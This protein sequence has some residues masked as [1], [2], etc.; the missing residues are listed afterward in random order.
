[1]NTA[2]WV[3]DMAY[4]LTQVLKLPIKSTAILYENQNIP[5]QS[6]VKFMQKAWEIWGVEVKSTDKFNL[7]DADCTQLVIKMRDLA[8]DFWQIAQ[9]LGWPIC[10]QA[11]ARQNYTPPQGRGG[12]YSGDENFVAQAGLAS[13]GVYAQHAGVQILK[14]TGQP[15]PYSATGRA[16]AV[17][18]YIFS[19]KKFSPTGADI[20]SMETIWSQ[21]FWQGGK[22]IDDAIR[23]QSGAITWKG[24]NQWIQSQTAWSGGL[25][26]PHGFVPTCKTGSP[27]WLFQWKNEGGKLVESDWQPYGGAIKLPASAKE[28]IAGGGECYLTR[29]ADAEL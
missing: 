4:Q 14:N 26:P 7:S 22:L 2:G 17:D 8:I 21:T 29:I 18:D 3:A 9:S 19:M 10:Q 5:V 13:A 12:P 1:M 27:T 6:V 24:V 16:P 20:A 15:Y 11:M 23:H 25:T 28:K